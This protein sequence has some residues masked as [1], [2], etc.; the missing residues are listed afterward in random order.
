MNIY[1]EAKIQADLD[2]LW[3]KTQ[4]PELH[5]QWDLRFTA[6]EYLPHDEA[7]SK[8]QRFLYSTRLGFGLAIKGEGETA[9][10]QDDSRGRRTS[11][12][13]FWSD[14]PKSLIREGAGYWQYIPVEGG[15]RFITGYDYGTRF[16]WLGRILD[17]LA[18]RP[19]MGWATAWSFDRLRLWIEKGI[20]PAVSMQ[21]MMIHALS[22]I[23][24]A[25][26][27]IYQGIVPKLI[28][29]HPDELAM[30]ADAGVPS[31]IVMRILML[32]GFAEMLLGALVL[33]YFRYR[34]P[35]VLTILLMVLA[36][37]GVVVNSPRYL[38][39]A[40]N[41]ISLNLLLTAVA[42]MG[43]IG[44]KDLPSAKRCL[45]KNPELES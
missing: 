10:S 32:V 36:T 1:V 26:V 43:L 7:T 20:D 13:R 9:G 29:N 37:I 44:M 28:A 31:G 42:V 40:F 5:E 30:L 35:L 11:S 14:D 19:L 4:T 23:A 12:L 3:E 45:R 22:R 6:I 41:P 21:R 17:K 15:I 24:V 38:G 18:F 33:I 16:G 34:W 8:P 2:E 39:A 27:W 25:V